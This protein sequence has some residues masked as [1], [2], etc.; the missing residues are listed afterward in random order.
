MRWFNSNQRYPVRDQCPIAVTIHWLEED[1]EEPQA[2][3][4]LSIGKTGARLC[5]S[6]PVQLYRSFSL[7]MESAELELNLATLA[8]IK[9]SKHLPSG[10]YLLE[11]GFSSDLP[12]QVFEKLRSGSEIDTREFKRDPASAVGQVTWETRPNIIPVRLHDIS[13]GG[14][15][16]ISPEPAETGSR[17]LFRAEHPFEKAVGIVATLQWQ[18]RN[19]KGYL[20]GC[21]F[22]NDGDY[23]LVQDLIDL[24]SEEETTRRRSRW[25]VVLISLAGV[26]A[27]AFLV[28]WF[29]RAAH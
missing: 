14:F 16:L 22:A 3:R 12:D 20:W 25:H 24:P 29:W 8:E 15:C 28:Q 27:I 5:S 17:L 21:K 19:E 10:D 23:F 7:S 1:G 6:I 18:A 13:R 2:V 4:L 11:C 9:L 26:G